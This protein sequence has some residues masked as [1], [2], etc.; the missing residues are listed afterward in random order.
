MYVRPDVARELGEALAHI[1]GSL[2]ELSRD[3]R[4]PGNLVPRIKALHAD[5]VRLQD[6]VGQIA[7]AQEGQPAEGTPPAGRAGRKFMQK[8]DALIGDNLSVE[9]IDMAF[10]TDKMNMSHSTFYRRLKALTGMTPVGYVRK[11][12][13]E[14][15]LGLLRAGEHS[16]SEISYMTGFNS[17]AHFRNAFKEEFGMPPSEYMKRHGAG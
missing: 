7:G 2:D 14:K 17:P 9:K 3:K 8:L 6:L 4:L 5:S 11:I 15:S 1:A 12:K 13:L 10:L 16:I